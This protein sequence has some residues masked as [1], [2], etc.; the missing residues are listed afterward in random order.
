MSTIFSY[1]R[2]E[3]ESRIQE[4]RLAKISKVVTFRSILLKI[5]GV[6]MKFSGLFCIFPFLCLNIQLSAVSLCHVNKYLPKDAIILEAGA[7]DGHDTLNFVA[8]FPQGMIYSFEPI[9]SYFDLVSNK[10]KDHKNVR[11]FNCALSSY[12]GQATFYFSRTNP[13][14]SSLLPA[15]KDYKS[16]YNDVEMTTPCI[17]LED[18]VCRYNIDHLDLMWLDMEGVEYHVLSSYPQIL[19]KTSCIILEVNYE[20]FRENMSLGDQIQELL[21]Q[22]GFVCTHIEGG[23]LQ[24]DQVWVKKSLL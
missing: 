8:S 4:F 21:T 15:N 14:A 3:V 24:N 1:T 19:E 20:E 7:Y 23:K 5:I 17:S 16:H 6:Q 11:L 9:P 13:G 10:I 22:Y 2:M 12:T 18:W